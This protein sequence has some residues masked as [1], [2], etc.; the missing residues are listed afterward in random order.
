MTFRAAYFGGTFDPVHAGH[1]AV[2]DRV[3]KLGLTD[4]VLFAPAFAPP[5]KQGRGMTGYVH[6]L[7]MLALALTGR[8]GCGVCDI[9]GRRAAV[10]SYTVD[11]L[12]ALKSE[13][14]EWSWQLLIGADSLVELS[15]WRRAR[16]LV[17]EFGIVTAPRPGVRVD[18]AELAQIWGGEIAARLAAGMFE[19]PGVDCSATE[20]RKK[21]SGKFVL[22][23]IM[24]YIEKCG[25]YPLGVESGEK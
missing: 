4:L 3:L 21:I 23:R 8:A 10:P 14:P 6:R 5:H 11:V 15:G 24:T 22:P 7:N 18:R 12:Q 16:E 9:E 1:L 19:M 17:G 20:I 13:H 25:L 2:A